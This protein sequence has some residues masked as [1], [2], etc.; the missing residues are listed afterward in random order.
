[1]TGIVEF[2]G[3]WKKRGRV[4]G[5][6]SYYAFRLYSTAD[7]DT[8]LAVENH[9]Q[10]YDVHHGITRFPEIS[11]VPYLDVVAAINKQGDGLTIFC[12]NRNLSQDI[13]A[14]IS[15]RGFRARPKGTVETLSAESIYAVNDEME[16]EAIKPVESTARVL[17]S[18]VRYTFRHESITRIELVAQ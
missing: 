11:S 1:M 17:N 6:P 16:P 18:E 7:I 3:I 8:P 5:T 4:Y 15:I 12:I 2:A 9:S 14:V 13:P 10:T